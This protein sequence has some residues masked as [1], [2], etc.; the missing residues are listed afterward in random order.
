ML[1]WMPSPPTG[2]LPPRLS[3]LPLPPHG[4]RLLLPFLAIVDA[5]AAADGWAKDDGAA[6]V[7]GGLCG[8][9]KNDG[10]GHHSIIDNLSRCSFPN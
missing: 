4:A 10:P 8:A 5:A 7:E 3:A 1:A 2:N 9:A 6:A